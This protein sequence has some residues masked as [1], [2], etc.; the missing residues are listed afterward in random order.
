MQPAVFRPPGRSGTSSTEGS[1]F[2]IDALFDFLNF[3]FVLRLAEIV[4]GLADQPMSERV[5]HGAL[6]EFEGGDAARS[7]QLLRRHHVQVF[8]MPHRRSGHR[9]IL[10][11]VGAEHFLDGREPRFSGYVETQR[12]ATQLEPGI[13]Q[14][15]SLDLVELALRQ[16]HRGL[17]R[18]RFRS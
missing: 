14:D 2:A 1:Q 11:I 5:D 7:I 12:I 15:R 13:G 18:L 8:R 6:K 10:E 17:G 9:T 3:A 16:L 4:H